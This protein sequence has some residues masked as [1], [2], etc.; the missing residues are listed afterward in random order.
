MRLLAAYFP[1]TEK[2]REQSGIE[3]EVHVQSETQK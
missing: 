2:L 1:M 3:I